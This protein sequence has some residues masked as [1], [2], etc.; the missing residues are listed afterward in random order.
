MALHLEELAHLIVLELKVVA[1]QVASG[2]L[3]LFV[4]LAEVHSLEFLHDGPQH[5]GHEVVRRHQRFG[6]KLQVIVVPN[7][8]KLYR[9]G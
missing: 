1:Y 4:D 2:F 9:Y 5:L 3:K 7:I 8:H 6:N